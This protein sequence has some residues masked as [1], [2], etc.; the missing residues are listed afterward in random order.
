MSEILNGARQLL[1]KEV[2]T[3]TQIEPKAHVFA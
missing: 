1:D 2:G 3:N